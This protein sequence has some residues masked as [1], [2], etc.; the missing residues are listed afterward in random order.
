MDS[1]AV[2]AYLI[3]IL[4]CC[5]FVHPRTSLGSLR[6][7]RS[8]KPGVSHFNDVTVEELETIRI[9]HA[10]SG[11]CL[12]PKGTI[13][14]TSA[15]ETSNTGQ[16]FRMTKTG[17]YAGKLKH[18]NS[19]TCMSVVANSEQVV[20]TSCSVSDRLTN[21]WKCHF[22]LVQ[23]G[24]TWLENDWAGLRVAS[25]TTPRCITVTSD[26]KVK[27]KDCTIYG[28]NSEQKIFVYGKKNMG[29]CVPAGNLAPR[30]T[31]TDYYYFNHAKFAL[32]WAMKYIEVYMVYNNGVV[33]AKAKIRVVLTGFE[34]WD[35]RDLANTGSTSSS[36]EVHG[37]FRAYS[38]M[39]RLQ[40][41]L[42]YDLAIHVFDKDLYGAAGTASS[43][44]CSQSS[45]NEVF[46][47]ATLGGQ[48][49]TRAKSLANILT[50]ELA[51]HFR[52]GHNFGA[53][54]Y[55]PVR[56]ITYLGVDARLEEMSMSYSV[57][58]SVA[59]TSR[60]PKG[61]SMG[62]FNS[63]RYYKF[64][65]LDNKPLQSTIVGC[66]NGV[67][68]PGE[69]CD[70][71][72]SEDCKL[73]DPCCDGS[74]CKLKRAFNTNVECSSEKC[75][76]NCKYDYTK[77]ACQVPVTKIEGR[78][79]GVISE[80][81][82]A[83]S[84]R[85]S[86]KITM[87]PGQTV[88]LII[89]LF[90]FEFD[91]GCPFDY[92]EVRD[93]GSRSSQLLGRYCRSP[94]NM[95]VKSSSNEVF[96]TF[97]SDSS[98][99]S[100]FKLIYTAT[101]DYQDDSNEVIVR[102]LRDSKCFGMDSSKK[103]IVTDS[104]CQDRFIWTNR[105]YI[106]HV[107]TGL[108][109][110]PRPWY[111]K[112]YPGARIEPTGD[113]SHY[114]SVFVPTSQGTIV[115]AV[116]GYCIYNNGYSLSLSNCGTQ[117]SYRFSV[118]TTTG[119]TTQPP[120]AQGQFRIRHFNQKCFNRESASSNKIQLKSTCD[121]LFHMNVNKQLVHSASGKCVAPQSS[122][123]NSLL[124]LQTSCTDNSKFESTATGALKHVSTGRCVH[125]LNGALD[126]KEGQFV[127]IY[128]GCDSDRLKFALEPVIPK[129]RTFSI[130]H[131]GGLCL[132]YRASNN[133]LRLISS[134][135]EKFTL[136]S[137]HALMH[138]QS[139][140]CVLPAGTFNG[141]SIGLSSDC[142]DANARFQQTASFSIKQL[143]TGKC[144]HPYMGSASPSIDTDAVIYS[145]CDDKR[146]QFKFI[147]DQM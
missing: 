85:K 141:A 26:K 21:I 108:C 74:I 59:V 113:C 60:W 34:V 97:R 51:H 76:T 126:P 129:V 16:L 58:F 102:S 19:N 112:Y 10:D 115:H 104:Q 91:E 41:G 96:V 56:H 30:T 82:N 29:V 33:Y 50:H 7:K 44:Y 38:R 146:V 63:I 119:P 106:K 24:R 121:D 13:I 73:R 66:G 9:Q 46:T 130:R 124:V 14:E 101:V 2:A 52:A 28:K 89:N 32:T 81:G 94:I 6:Q 131:Y 79:Y 144:V 27:A 128:T 143:S 12:E 39:L 118:E 111:G 100:N 88:T 23:Q 25:G 68:E 64:S 78:S 116:S 93:G 15:C 69:E 17:T 140:K 137:T 1:T 40:K 103:Y 95:Q 136:T 107:G 132:S 122:G 139:G 65:C 134:C 53:I 48:D 92:I 35:Q 109:I 83:V 125:P 72:S 123:D 62:E 98:F 3:L 110:S 36:Q 55:I 54:P 11:L 86:W 57:I 43:H 22:P 147:Y 133:R 18:I 145:G 70:C 71:G 42:K 75:C 87:Q 114:G 47:M 120:P 5:S 67:I 8:V 84:Q 4:G 20:L 77:T 138:V 90:D 105:F 117:T 61:F 135:T 127:V 31:S 37:N 142:N 99:P 45:W 49:K 80:I